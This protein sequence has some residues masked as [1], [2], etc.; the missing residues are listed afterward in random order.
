MSN[1][2]STSFG[3]KFAFLLASHDKSER[4]KGI[5]LIQRWLQVNRTISRDEMLRMWLALHYC[6]LN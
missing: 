6:K 2:A 1:N 5:D 4:D 3:K